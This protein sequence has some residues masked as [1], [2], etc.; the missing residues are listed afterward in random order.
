MTK[1]VGFRLSQRY[2]GLRLCLLRC[3]GW[4][5]W[6]ANLRCASTRKSEGVKRKA[7]GAP[8][9]FTCTFVTQM[10]V[11]EETVSIAA[12]TERSVGEVE[13][14]SPILL[15]TSR[16]SRRPQCELL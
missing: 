6:A 14:P 8:S 10:Q 1:V 9:V 12:H 4:F 13:M 5:G 7:Y 2:S 11:I 15:S 16:N 3:V